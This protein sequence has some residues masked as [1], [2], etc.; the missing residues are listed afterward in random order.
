MAKNSFQRLK[1]TIGKLNISPK[2][3]ILTPIPQL[4]QEKIHFF[5]RVRFKIS[6]QKPNYLII[7]LNSIFLPCVFLHETPPK[8]PLNT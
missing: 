1:N 8:H 2:N 5:K 7:N 6:S 4:T 3:P